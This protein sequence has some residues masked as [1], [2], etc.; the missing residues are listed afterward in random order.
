MGP[1]HQFTTHHAQFTPRVGVVA[2]V[3]ADEG[4]SGDFSVGRPI[5]QIHLQHLGA[6]LFIRQAVMLAQ[7]FP[8][9]LGNQRE[10]FHLAF[11]PCQ[12]GRSILG[13]TAGALGGALGRV[14]ALLLM[15]AS[16]DLAARFKGAV[17][18]SNGSGGSY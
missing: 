1:F 9:G 7:Q 15:R 3:A 10:V 16:R 13:F 12:F 6:Q 11:Q 8:H 18:A 5:T 4:L 17:S 14:D 2:A